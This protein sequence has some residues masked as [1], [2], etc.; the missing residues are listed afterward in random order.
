MLLPA[1]AQLGYPVLAALV[2]GESARYGAL[3]VFFGRWV[4]GVRVVAAVSAGAT[5]MPW[6]RFAVANALGAVTWAAT[7]AGLAA[8]VGGVGAAVL[9]ATGLAAGAAVIGVGLLRAR[10]ARR[11]A[12]AAQL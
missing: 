7:V 11:L 10:R 2:L 12:T 4:P 6:R 3:T 9:A 5:R 1:P 8:A